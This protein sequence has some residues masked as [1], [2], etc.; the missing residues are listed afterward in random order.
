[1]VRFIN[2]NI[3]KI[4]GTKEVTTIL[5]YASDLIEYGAQLDAYYFSIPYYLNMSGMG[6]RVVS[7]EGLLCSISIVSYSDFTTASPNGLCNIGIFY[8]VY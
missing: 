6:M 1:M 8:F 2:F 5:G 7:F 3:H 4:W